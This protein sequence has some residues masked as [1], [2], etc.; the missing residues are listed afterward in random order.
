MVGTG[1]YARREAKGLDSE[2]I[3]AT[4]I[5]LQLRPTSDA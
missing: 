1:R 5:L 2:D 4:L 3:T